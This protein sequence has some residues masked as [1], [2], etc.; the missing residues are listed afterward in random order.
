MKDSKYRSYYLFSLLGVIAASAY[1]LYMGIS[2]LMKIIR[3]G[4]VPL[5]EYPKYIIPYA[6]IAVS[7]IA[8]VLAIPLFQKL[9][10]KLDLLFG[11]GLSI[12][13]FFFSERFMETKVLVTKVLGQAQDFVSLESWQMSLCYVP[14][15]QYE[16]RTWKA[17]DVLL[18]GYSPAFKMH[19]YLISVVIVLSLLNCFY[20]FAKMIR[21]GDYGRKKA[22]T[23]Q[24]ATGVVFLGMCIWACF[25]AFYR[26]GEITVSPLSAVLMAV[27]FA[28]LGVTAGVFV[29]SYT[30]G[31]RKLFSQTVPSVT[32]ILV[33]IAMYI[34]ETI[35]LSG[36]L[37]RF[38]TG[39]L[40]EEFVNLAL[41]PIDLII[42]LA[43]G[44]ITFLICHKL[45]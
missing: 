9:S 44:A 27:F 29:G 28:L 6:P 41:A 40:F 21:S 35:L 17:V 13:V 24:A 2:V 3:D 26:T 19:F 32:A 45:V 18:G 39:F 11:A 5:E 1:P 25:T 23:I 8:G 7:L 14:P 33:T 20:G 30:L 15:E 37:Y 42:I 38:G 12:A 4:Y 36:N 43:S 22:L 10:R 31:K 16:T 34:G